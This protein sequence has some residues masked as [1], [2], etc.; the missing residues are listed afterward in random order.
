MLSN[1]RLKTQPDP[2]TGARAPMPTD[3]QQHFDLLDTDDPLSAALC[4]DGVRDI[5]IEDSEVL[6]TLD[7]ML[8]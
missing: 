1:K 8:F 3:Q 4:F 2:S 5:P 7:S 6:P